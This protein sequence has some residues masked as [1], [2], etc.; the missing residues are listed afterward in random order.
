MSF[1]IPRRAAPAALVLLAAALAGCEADAREPSPPTVSTAPAADREERFSVYALADEPWRDA[2]GEERTLA[3]LA[4]RVQVVAMVY[5]HCAHTCPRIVADLKR[6][7]AEVEAT[8]PGAAGLVLVTLDP[9]RDTPERLREFAEGARLA[10]ERWT[11]LAG[12][13]EG[14]RA[15]AALLSVRYREEAGREIAH[16]NA[17]IVLDRAGRIVHR[18]EALDEPLEATVEAVRRAAG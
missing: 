18:R 13:E 15:L 9:A 14:T 17:L 5:T 10:P 12:T 4:G 1:S 16:T 11:L 6:V 2:T 3:S 8:H 7:E